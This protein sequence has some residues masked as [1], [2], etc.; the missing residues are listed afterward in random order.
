[1]ST[2]RKGS[3][4]EEEEGMT[5]DEEEGMTIDEFNKENEQ[6]GEELMPGVYLKKLVQCEDAPIP[7]FRQWVRFSWVGK[8]KDDELFSAKREAWAKLGDGDVPPGIELGVRALKLNEKGILSCGSRFAYGN[9]IRPKRKEGI[10]IIPLPENS[11]VN[12]ELH[13]LELGSSLPVGSMNELDRIKEGQMK[14]I[15]GNELFLYNDFTRSTRAYSAALKAIDGLLEQAMKNNNDND[16]DDDDDDNDDKTK[17]EKTVE[18]HSQTVEGGTQD[19][20]ESV[21][22]SDQYDNILKLMIDCGCNIAA[23]YLKLN[24]YNKA[25]N[26]CIAVLQCDAFNIKAL[27]RGG[28]S[29]MYQSKYLESKLAFNKILSIDPNN[30]ETK[31]KLIELNKKELL[32]LKKE[33]QIAQKMGA[34]MFGNN[35]KKPSVPSSSNK[36]SEKTEK[37]KES[38]KTEK[39]NDKSNI[40]EEEEEESQPKKDKDDKDEKDENDDEKENETTTQIGHDVSKIETSPNSSEL[41][42][43]ILMVT[44]FIMLIAV[45][46][47][48]MQIA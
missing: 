9:I 28:V 19:G 40:K 11:D 44:L 22:I 23:A 8:T 13:V 46:L 15:I 45:V 12:I 42:T 6:K 24:E 20:G 32:Y 18:E 36:E 38:E 39:T 29:A 26:A 27:Y 5:I 17:N 3:D 48:F 14:K 34:N 37:Y 41:T 31:K 10:D 16:N 43:Q 2:D 33:K 47:R 1:M 30:I 25:E 4:T 21:D 35:S 7:D